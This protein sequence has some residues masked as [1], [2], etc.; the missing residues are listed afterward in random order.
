VEQSIYWNG[1]FDFWTSKRER[2][3]MCIGGRG[4]APPEHCGGP[5]AYRLVL[6]RQK[7][8]ES[9]CTP[10]QV[11]SLIGMYSASDPDR[12]LSSWDILRKALQGGFQ[13]VVGRRLQE[14]GP[15][16]PNH[17]SL[18]EAN[19]GLAHQVERGRFRA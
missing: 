6:K 13:S 17:F 9:M 7:E 2:T 1:S 12:L 18:Q 10:A 11:E 14:F 4:A 15:R 3:A 16:E 19:Q 8:G 5:T